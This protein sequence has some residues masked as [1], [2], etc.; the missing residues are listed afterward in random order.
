MGKPVGRSTAIRPACSPEPF[1]AV[2]CA[3]APHPPDPQDGASGTSRRRPHPGRP[4]QEGAQK[5]AC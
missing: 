2:P 4:V 1:G 3:A 5:K